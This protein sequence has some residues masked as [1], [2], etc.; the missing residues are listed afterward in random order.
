MIHQFTSIPDLCT[1]YLNYIAKS[2]RSPALI[3]NLSDIPF[4]IYRV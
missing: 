3:M 2:I 1:L 4:L